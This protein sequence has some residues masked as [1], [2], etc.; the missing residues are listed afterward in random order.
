MSDIFKFPNGGYE[1]EV[2]RKQDILD[3][4]DDNI[5]DKEVALALI[6]QC[7]VDATNFLKEGRWTG[8]P[9]LGNMRVPTYKKKFKEIGG[10]EILEAAKQ[11]L[12]KD[13]YI[14]FRKQL[15]INIAADI[16][17]ERYYKYITS[18]FVTKHKKL[19][20]SFYKDLRSGKLQDKDAY[21]RFMC[22]SCTELSNYIPLDY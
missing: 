5:I 14:I 11:D 6:T 8:I 1:I 12:D 17:Y 2:C 13:K 22:Y 21:A 15:N 19:Y 3:C 20:N 18:C 10:E 7:E 9:F 4:I 16:K